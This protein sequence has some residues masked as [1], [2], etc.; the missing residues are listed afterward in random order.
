MGEKAGPSLPNLY[1]R[2]RGRGGGEEKA[3]RGHV[4][5]TQIP[6]H[7]RQ[8]SIFNYHRPL[9]SGLSSVPTPPSPPPPLRPSFQGQ[10]PFN[11]LPSGTL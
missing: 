3:Y 1:L 5:L 2:G 7:N 8:G 4:P 11:F 9:P 10:F 6:V